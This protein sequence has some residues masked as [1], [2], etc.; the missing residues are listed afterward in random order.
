MAV[1][2]W[3]IEAWS[4]P[5]Q[6]SFGRTI[7]EV[8]G[9]W[10]IRDVAPGTGRINGKI[11]ATWPRM[12]ELSDPNND[13][14][15]LL[16]LYQ[17]DEAGIK[18]IKLEFEARRAYR[19]Y[20]EDSGQIWT[21]T[22]PSIT[23]NLD[24]AVVYPFQW[25]PEPATGLT[26]TVLDWLYGE[27]NTLLDN[28]GF[29]DSANFNGFE[30]DELEGWSEATAIEGSD[31]LI[32]GPE[33]S[34]DEARTG[35]RSLEFDP[36]GQSGAPHSGVE[37][38]IDVIPGERIQIQMY[39]KSLTTGRR[40]TAYALMDKDSSGAVHHSTNGFTFSGDF[41]IELDN[42]ARAA[43]KDGTPGGSTDG[44]WQSFL[45]DLTVGDDQESLT[46]GVVYDHHGTPNGPVAYLDDV[47]VS[48]FGAGLTPWFSVRDLTTFEVDTSVIRTGTNSL[49]M[50]TGGGGI[51]QDG[52]GQP[53][54]LI[55]GRPYTFSIWVRHDAGADRDFRLIAV[56]TGAGWMASQ[57]ATVP[58]DTWTKITLGFNADAEDAIF[59]L[60]YSETGVSPNVYLDDA[61]A[62]EGQPATTVTAI[63]GAL[64][65]DA[66]T[67]HS[68][69]A[70]PNDRATLTWLKEDYTDTLDSAG[71]ALPGDVSYRV[72]VGK[73]YAQVASDFAGLG[74]EIQIVPN[75]NWPSPDTETHLLQI[76][77]RYDSATF[78]GGIGT[79]KT[80]TVG[81]NAGQGITGGPIT[82]SP[83]SRTVA[84][85]LSGEISAVSQDIPGIAAW[86]SREI[87]VSE[88]NA[89]DQPT[90]QESADTVLAER[91]ALINAS[92][93]TIGDAGAI[94]PYLDF[95]PGD[96]I[97]MSLLPDITRGDR[98]C[99][100]VT[101]SINEKPVEYQVDFDA[102]VFSGAAAQAEAVSRLLGQFDA[103]PPESA[104]LSSVDLAHSHAK[105]SV[106]TFL[107]AS[108]TA[109]REVIAMADFICSGVDDQVEIQA[110]VTALE[111]LGGG[112]VV[113]SQGDFWLDDRVIIGGDDIVLMGMGI[114]STR[115]YNRVTIPSTRTAMLEASATGYNSV[116]DMTVEYTRSGAGEIDYAI[117]CNGTTYVE[118]CRV[119]FSGGTGEGNEAGILTGGFNNVV[120]DC[121]FTSFTDNSDAVL[122]GGD[123]DAVIGCHFDQI[124][125]A[126]ISSFGDHLLILGNR[127]NCVGFGGTAIYASGD[128]LAI[129]GNEIDRADG[130]RVI[131]LDAVTFSVVANNVVLNDGGAAELCL[132]I[133]GG[134]Y[135][136]VVGN[137]FD[138][139]AGAETVAVRAA[140]DWSTIVGN[141]L[142]RGG[143]RVDGALDCLVVGNTFHMSTKASAEAVLLDGTTF[144]VSDVL[145]ADN[146]IDGV[147]TGVDAIKLDGGSA[148]VAKAA[149]RGNQ[150]TGGSATA[151]GID[152]QGTGSTMDEIVVEN[153]TV[154]GAGTF[155]TVDVPTS[156]TWAGFT[157]S[158][159]I[160][161]AATGIALTTGAS[162]KIQ[163]LTI[164]GNRFEEGGKTDIG[165]CENLTITGNS[166]TVKDD[167]VDVAHLNVDQADRAL[168]SHNF[169][170]KGLSGTPDALL[171]V[172]AGNGV[173]VRGNAFTGHDGGI[174]DACIEIGA[175]DVTVEGNTYLG[176][177]I[178]ATAVAAGG[179]LETGARLLS[180]ATVIIGYNTF[181]LCQTQEYDDQTTGGVTFTGPAAIHDNVAGEIAA[182]TEKGT[183]VSADLII[184]E[185]SAASNV[186]KKVQVTNLPGFG[187]SDA[188]AIHDNVAAEI[189]AITEKTTPVS[190]DLIVI[191]DSAA[192]NAKKRVQIGNLPGGSGGVPADSWLGRLFA[193]DGSAHGDDEEFNDTIG[194]TAVTPTGTATWTQDGHVLSVAFHDI[195]ADD[196]ASRL[197]ALTPSSSPITIET[198]CRLLSE[199]VDHSLVG[200]VFADGTASTSNVATLYYRNSNTSGPGFKQRSGTATAL[201][202]DE[203]G[204]DIVVAGSGW[205]F[206][207]LVWTAANTFD[208]SVSI[209][210]ITWD[211]FRMS[212]FSKTMTPTHFG[213]WVSNFHDT[214][215]HESIGSFEYLRVTETDLS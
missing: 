58:T 136:R 19:L 106:P 29:E 181:D 82:R 71:N 100:G 129:I 116:R 133:N 4:H 36:D 94:R 193:V 53:L 152:I 208:V 110:A 10:S 145:V 161:D 126:Y 158:G 16:R 215:A 20:G 76:F 154:Y 142:Y 15:S 137:L 155:L 214:N 27:D 30:G 199:D 135:N 172:T 104:A 171:T 25:P 148:G 67:D 7:S 191:E 84:L 147:A 40:F 163:T 97:K 51:D 85:A 151:A 95:I 91:T 66:Q 188:D 62:A 5:R 212:S 146:L 184:I 109:R 117:W 107:V 92:Q 131:H 201:T 59:E 63:F 99:R 89:L 80:T 35:S 11:P 144:G 149:I 174:T 132:D 112:R 79:D 6:G 50:V 150:I 190:G 13:V 111:V 14:G 198:A 101:F 195:D 205:V 12:D 160:T 32:S 88:P 28:P 156:Q 170:A 124:G 72:N 57:L 81:I 38:T 162:G 23:E 182:L 197:Y 166:W 202:S 24:D 9:T 108:S 189:S 54:E 74:Y 83:L 102:L 122:I 123:R 168:I 52:V 61:S 26:L 45:L 77:N 128:H 169:I 194:G 47:T 17:V 114:E 200:L 167:T 46:F 96:T 206:M 211:D 86:G 65:A 37:K 42:V 78:V 87:F 177:T 98:R 118:R 33:P 192:S 41:F 39:L 183:P 176:K 141:T 8:P 139:G 43:A 204:A 75:P 127:L 3:S 64:M 103:P 143:I 34:T 120:R 18:Q 165:D 164:R 175:D 48:G 185:D 31:P 213:V 70:P 196:I 21:V 134:T 203:G 179:E 55:D 178:D 69:E 140:G 115:V 210:G 22:G 49:K 180:G 60:R 105:E 159:N 68:G 157:I 207:R 1:G 119:G 209:D 138:A 73:S 173:V 121:E 186:K 113:L 130:T 2:D 153:N 90:L 44:T 125:G 56:R 187:G 93:V